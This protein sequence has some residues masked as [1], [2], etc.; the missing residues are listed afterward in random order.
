[1]T[2]VLTAEAGTTQM[3][4]PQKNLEHLLNSRAVSRYRAEWFRLATGAR[5]R[6]QQMLVFQSELR[7][8]IKEK[9]MFSSECLSLASTVESLTY[10]H[11]ILEVKKEQEASVGRNATDGCLKQTPPSHG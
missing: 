4:E 6:E 3:Q 1:M 11:P 10:V 2:L 9:Q 7:A 5:E 8:A